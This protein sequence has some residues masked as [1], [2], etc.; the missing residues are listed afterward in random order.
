MVRRTDALF[1]AILWDS[2][3]SGL[4]QLCFQSLNTRKGET[5]RHSAFQ[6][7]NT[8]EEAIEGKRLTDDSIVH[9]KTYCLL[10]PSRFP[11]LFFSLSRARSSFPASSYSL[12][13]FH[14]LS[15]PSISLAVSLAFLHVL[16]TRTRALTQSLSFSVSVCVCSLP[17]SSIFSIS[18]LSP[19]HVVAFLDLACLFY[20]FLL[21][22]FSYC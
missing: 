13:V 4:A 2:Q 15:S 9:S 3:V 14:A 21:L 11:P 10:S 8:S 12:F 20:Y 7:D 6:I 1:A 18:L 19:S 22:L 5:P 16:L 17:S